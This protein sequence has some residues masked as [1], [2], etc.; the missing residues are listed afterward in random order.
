MKYIKQLTVILIITF[1]SEMLHFLLP[2][3]IPASIYGMAIL[4]FALQSK[5]LRLDS[6]KDVGKFL[7][8]IM[9]VF[10]IPAAVGLIDTWQLL[11][12]YLVQIVITIV[13]T[14][15]VVMIVAGKVTQFVIRLEAKK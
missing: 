14:T 6:V 9:P 15:F 7:N 1:A 5:L 4:F 8:E 12:N 3:P 2:L 13:S 10:F 11:G